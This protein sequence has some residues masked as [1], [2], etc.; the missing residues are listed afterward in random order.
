M[1]RTRRS[2]IYHVG[3]VGTTY[4][5]HST[6]EDETKEPPQ[7]SAVR[8]R[9]AFCC[10]CLASSAAVTISQFLDLRVRKSVAQFKTTFASIRIPVYEPSED[11]SLII[12]DWAV[13]LAVALDASAAKVAALDSALA[14]KEEDCAQLAKQLSNLVS[15]KHEHEE[16]LLV[17]F[18]ALLD[19]KK[20]KIRELSRNTKPIE[21][22]E[23]MHTAVYAHH[24]LTIH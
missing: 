8:S 21:D 10:R 14:H 9:D 5:Q 1:G 2:H 15:E 22:D 7:P 18:K 19:A 24:S 6:L 13:D 20:A 4:K 17:K 12:F 16:L 11:D 3:R 23:G